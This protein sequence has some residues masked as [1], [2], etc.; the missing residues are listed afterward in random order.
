[1]SATIRGTLGF[2]GSYVPGIAADGLR[3][4]SDIFLRNGFKA[5]DEVRLLG[6]NIGGDLDCTNSKLEAGKSGRTLNAD[7]I[8]VDRSV[9]L[10]DGFNANGEVR[11][12][13]AEIGGNLDCTNAEFNAGKTKWALNADGVRGDKN[14]SLSNA[15]KAT[16]NLNFNST[17]IENN[18]FVVGAN[19]N[20]NENFNLE[21]SNVKGTYFLTKCSPAMNNIQLSGA[22]VG[23]LEDDEKSWGIGL[24]LHHFAYDKIS[25]AS[26]MTAEMRIAWLDKQ[27]PRLLGEG[28]D[29]VL[30]PQPWLRGRKVL[31]EA[32]YYEEAKKVGIAFERRRKFKA[33]NPYIGFF[34]NYMVALPGLGIGRLCCFILVLLC[35]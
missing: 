4:I 14:I 31:N 12:L 34:I 3:T 30:A 13:L 5:G 1:M 27:L 10:R 22:H 11:L 6:A 8:K 15:F 2:D 9:F 16:G 20:D 18:F 33:G 24:N 17:K 28:K 29:S 23:M 26:P 21:N 35:G 32:G 7:G 19:I 25:D